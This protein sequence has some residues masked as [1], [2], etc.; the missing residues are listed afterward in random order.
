MVFTQQIINQFISQIYHELFYFEITMQDSTK[1]PHS[2][3]G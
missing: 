1:G 2:H 3:L